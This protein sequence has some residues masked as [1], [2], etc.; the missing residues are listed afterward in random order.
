M[1]CRHGALLAALVTFLS[2]PCGR[3]CDSLHKSAYVGKGLG[4]FHASCQLELGSDKEL[5]R[6]MVNLRSLR[7][8]PSLLGPTLT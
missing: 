3:V 8:E 2:Y 6:C 5:Y 7:L 1:F 4:A